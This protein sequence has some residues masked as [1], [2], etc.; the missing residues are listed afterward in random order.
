MSDNASPDLRES[1]RLAL[2]LARSNRSLFID[3]MADPMR[4]H[5]AFDVVERTVVS[6]LQK[7]KTASGF[8]ISCLAM[9][10][11][12]RWMKQLR[13]LSV[14]LSRCSN[15]TVPAGSSRAFFNLFD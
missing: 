4:R 5:I 11:Q 15:K 12:P 2:Q 3:A 1:M 13:N 10:N 9:S 6:D 8:I 7:V 14:S